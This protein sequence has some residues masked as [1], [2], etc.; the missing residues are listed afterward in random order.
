M[1]R[2]LIGVLCSVLLGVALQAVPARAQPEIPEVAQ[3]EDPLN[4]SNF[5]NDQDFYVEGGCES[6]CEGDHV[7]PADAGSVS[8]FLK[9]WF[10]NDA[11]TFSVHFQTEA[12]PPA[13]STVLFRVYTNPPGDGIECAQ[14]RG[15]LTINA[16]F[17]GEYMG[18]DVSTYRSD[19]FTELIDST[20][21]DAATDGE[22]TI[23]VGPE[24][25]GITT[26]TF[27]RSA[28]A[29]LGPGGVIKAPFA[30]GRVVVGLD[31]ANWRS[32]L[33]SDNTM[34]GTDYALKDE[35]AKKCPKKKAKKKKCPK[36]GGSPSPSPTGSVSPSPT[37]T[38]A[39]PPDMDSGRPWFVL[40][41]WSNLQQ[42]WAR[43]V[44]RVYEL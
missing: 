29:L 36:P 6:P 5:L 44:G 4:D 17:P 26:L 19:Q 16:V 11:T 12:A 8:D 31:R 34:R 21:E 2:F 15:C 1:K 25:T 40:R 32:A 35:P 42:V 22:V 13:T 18:N 33:Q 10:T 3:I 23:E 7:T 38:T 43:L 28:S 24:E 39:A 41:V 9:V 37:A 27:P 20:N 14:P 30:T